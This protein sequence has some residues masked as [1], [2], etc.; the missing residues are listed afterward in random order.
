MGIRACNTH[1]IS[2]LKGWYVYRTPHP[3]RAFH[4]EGVALFRFFLLL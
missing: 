2:T 1:C 3:P 4:P